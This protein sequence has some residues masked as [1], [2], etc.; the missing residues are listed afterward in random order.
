MFFAFRGIDFSEMLSG[1]QQAN[2]W[3]FGA[4][5]LGYLCT[6]AIRTLRLWLL[7]DHRGTYASIFS[8]NTIGFLA[9]NV[10]PLRMGELVRPYLLVE[11][12]NLPFGEAMVAIVLE[13]WLDM[14]M[15]LIMLF[16]LGWFIDLPNGIVVQGIDILAAGQRTLGTM[17][18]LGFIGLGALIAFGEP[19]L[20]PLKE[21]RN[22]LL[23]KVVG[24][25]LS[26]RE[27]AHRLFGNPKLALRAFVV[28]CAVWGT[29]ML[30]IW[31]A[32]LGFPD[33]PNSVGVVWS[34]WT[35]TLVGMV[36]AP[37]PGF[38]G[39]Y[40]LFCATALWLWGVDK[41]DGT[42]F[43]LTLH[44]SQL[45]FTVAIGSIFVLK[46]GINLRSLVKDSR[47]STE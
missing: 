46:E 35:I 24:F 25:I 43:A 45:F 10:I 2:L 3:Y 15:L 4:V 32:L 23:V 41:V 26:L 19:I 13:R 12:E 39:V 36:V 38:I 30:A 29:T 33:F 6:H 17:V 11:K 27:G 47:A 34:V 18:V 21:H 5:C 40:E 9:I 42:A 44:A 22:P 20:T 31:F 16:G 28:S 14:I 1:I 37:T 7:I 8:I